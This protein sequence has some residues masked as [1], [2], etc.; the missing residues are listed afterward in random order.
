[1]ITAM[2]Y[3]IPIPQSSAE[4]LVDPERTSYRAPAI[5][6]GVAAVTAVQFFTISVY[7]G[8]YET[9]LI[10]HHSSSCVPYLASL[11]SWNFMLNE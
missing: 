8:H 7:E 4:S 1:M 6:R 5:T 9:Q 2:D 3:F 10:R 11:L